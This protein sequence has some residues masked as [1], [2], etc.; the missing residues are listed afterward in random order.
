MEDQTITQDGAIKSL[1]QRLRNMFH[2]GIKLSPQEETIMNILYK[3]LSLPDTQKVT[4]VGRAYFVLNENLHYCIRIGYGSV[5]I[6][7][8]VD[9]V[10]RDCSASFSDFAKEAVDREVRKDIEKIEGS[11]FK[12]EMKV[13]EKIEAR[14]KNAE[15]T[16]TA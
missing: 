14:I 10:T 13:L 16:P 5:A 3:L 15:S 11:L 6:V 4:P 8:S 2:P 12:S 7:N 9:S 1:N